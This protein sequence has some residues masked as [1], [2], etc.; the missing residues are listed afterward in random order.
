[1]IGHSVIGI[2]AKNSLS[3]VEAIFNAYV[4]TTPIV[5]LRS[6]DDQLR[7]ELTGVTHVIDSDSTFGWF[8]SSYVFS[9]DDSLAQVS[10]TSGTEGE[11]KGVLLTHKALS[12]VTYRLNNVMEVDSSIREYVGVPAHFSFGLGRFRAIA[13]VGGRAFLPEMGFNPL[14]IRDMLKQ[15]DINAVSAVPTLWRVLLKNKA[16]FGLEASNLKWIEIGSQYM[17]RKEKEELKI[18]FSNAVIV[19]HYG[20]TEASRTTFLRIDQECENKLESVGIVTGISEIKISESGRICIRGPHVAN[21]LLK[22]ECFT[23]NVDGAGWFETNDLGVIQN[24]YLYYQGRADDLIN[25]SG[26]K[27][28][29][30]ALECDLQEFLN[31]KEGIAISGY[32]DDLVGNGVLVAKKKKLELEAHEIFTAIVEILLDYGVNNKNAVKVIQL[33]EFPVTST[34]KIQ[35]KEL[36][37]LY[38]AGRNEAFEYVFQ[39]NNYIA[40]R[41]DFELSLAVVWKKILKLE[42]VGIA[43]DFFDLGGGSLTAVMLV[44]EMELA[45]GIKFDIGDVFSFPTIEQLVSLQQEGKQKVASSI[46][47]L[48]EKGSG[49][50]L[51]CLCGIN[52][53][54]ELANSLGTTQAVYG[55]YVAEE[56]A[57]M[58]ALIEGIDLDLSVV[59]LAQLYSDA[60]LRKQPEGPYQLAGI[61]FGGLL[62]IETAR[63]LQKKGA[64]VAVVILLD[65]ILPSAVLRSLLSKLKRRVKL[66]IGK[67]QKMYKLAE[68]EEQKLS[69]M[70]D[71]RDQAYRKAMEAYNVPGEYYHG[72][73]VLIKAKEQKWGKGVSL[74]DDYGWGDIISGDV[75]TYEMEG[76]HLGIIKKPNVSALAEQLKVYL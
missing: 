72:K 38:I 41:N 35:R 48:Q 18:L 67:V 39:T 26:I 7:K 6:T 13:A 19:Q 10:F 55:I 23:S 54:Q 50:P 46:V 51:F 57:L 31:I 29:P 49:L 27:L 56:Q 36:S 44:N 34:G 15:Q 20:L 12:D 61:S 22:Q 62:A 64:E 47:P 5:L 68:N 24:G 58:S 25:C 2:V 52:I 75:I 8:S 4:D 30:D 40:P 70:M 21:Q 3:Y 43:D 14:E 73:V 11:P 1:M 53:Y 60:I 71:L 63:I 28:S 37:K 66:C 69:E 42:R 33:D 74:K 9:D 45:S 16:I 59:H 76:D 17:S 32:E 65:T